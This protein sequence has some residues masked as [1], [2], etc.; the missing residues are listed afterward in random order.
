MSLFAGTAA[1]RANV[2]GP[3]DT[4]DDTPPPDHFRPFKIALPGDRLAT[5]VPL[6][7]APLWVERDTRR[8]A[9]FGDLP[10]KD[11]VLVAA[12]P[13]QALHGR[14]HF[15][16]YR[17]VP[18]PPGAPFGGGSEIRIGAVLPNE[19]ARWR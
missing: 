11:L 1:P 14:H 9:P 8:L 19:A 7:E 12:Y 16:I 2:G 15:V 17:Q 4:D 13:L 5:D 3:C 6:V 18:A 10:Y